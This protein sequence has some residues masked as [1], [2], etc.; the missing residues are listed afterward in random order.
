MN[1]TLS[2]MDRDRRERS[3]LLAAVCGKLVQ[4]NGMFENSVLSWLQLRVITYQKRLEVSIRN[5]NTKDGEIDKLYSG[6][7][8]V[9]IPA[10][11]QFLGCDSRVERAAINFRGA[12]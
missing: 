3:A 2:H 7:S 6:L 1:D 8:V 11:G 4:E 5:A 12:P 10:P 9:F